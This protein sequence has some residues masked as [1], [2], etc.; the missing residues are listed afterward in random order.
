[1]T[2]SNTYDHVQKVNERLA[3]I[4][5]QEVLSQPQAQ[6]VVTQQAHQRGAMPMPEVEGL[7]GA[8]E[9]GRSAEGAVDTAAGA[10]IEGLGVVLD[11]AAPP[12]PDPAVKQ[13]WRRSQ[14]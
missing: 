10:V 13:R 12:P 6:E 3:S 7:P 2:A 14:G 11:A 5:P 1:M 8:W 9:I 4:Q